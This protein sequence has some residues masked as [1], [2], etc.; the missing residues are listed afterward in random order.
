MDFAHFMRIERE[1]DGRT[2]HY[3]VHTH[4]PKFSVELAPDGDA[5]DHIGTGV[6]K[7]LLLPNSWTGNYT[8]CSKLVTAAQEFFRQSFAEPA[9]KEETRRFQV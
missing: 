2:R 5:P 8:Q 4:D 1:V 7:A 3:V 6:I 9:P